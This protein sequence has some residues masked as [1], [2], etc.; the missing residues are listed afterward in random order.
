MWLYIIFVVSL[1][2][3]LLSTRRV[4]ESFLDHSGK[5]NIDMTKVTNM[6]LDAA[7][8]TSEVKGHYKKLLIFAAKDI[9]MTA[10]QPLQGLRILADFR[11]RVFGR[12]DF[13]EDLTVKDFTDPWP[14][15]LPPLD[16]TQSEPIP[17][18]DEA[19]NAE[20]KILAYLQRN[21]PQDLAEKVDDQTHSTIWNILHDFGDRFVFNQ[22][23]KEG[24][25]LIIGAARKEGETFE[26]GPN[27]L[28]VPLTKGWSNPAVKA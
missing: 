23:R 1:A 4:R 8:T 14:E 16:T 9:A 26:L 25:P 5:V 10:Q 21:F 17:T 3:L 27:F 13:R 12:R 28:T 11:D 2:A 7:P 15:W 6:A 18:A 19:A 24:E 20:L 22:P